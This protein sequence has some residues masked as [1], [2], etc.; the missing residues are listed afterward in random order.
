MPGGGAVISGLTAPGRQCQ[1]PSKYGRER[2]A[3]IGCRVVVFVLMGMA[4]MP[5]HAQAAGAG[6]ASAYLVTYFETAPAAADAVAGTLKQYAADSGKAAGNV[7]F[8][9]F[10]ELGRGN[11]FAFFEGWRDKAA[12]EAHGQEATALQNRLQPQIA[13]PFDSRTSSP[14]LVAGSGQGAAAPVGAVYVM[15]HVDVPGPAKDECIELL[16]RLTAAARTEPGLLRF[17][18]VQQD[19]RPNHFTVLEIWRDKG[20]YDAHMMTEATRAFRRGLTP[21][22]GALYD[23]RLYEALR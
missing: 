9:A 5:A 4:M 1:R 3:A 20:A 19:S 15:T 6:A 22:A 14:M 7:E 16:K 17:D 12:L 11:R 18:V 8:L 2:M 10:R 13:A 21:I 23:E